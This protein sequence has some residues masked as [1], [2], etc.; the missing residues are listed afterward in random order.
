MPESVFCQRGNWMSSALDVFLLT[1]HL[2][3]VKIKEH[4]HQLKRFDDFGFAGMKEDKESRLTNMR[5]DGRCD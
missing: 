2:V 1:P 4:D 3:C 5:R